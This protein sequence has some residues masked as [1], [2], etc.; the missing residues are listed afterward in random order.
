RMARDAGWETAE[1]PH[2]SVALF[3][4]IFAYFTN[5]PTLQRLA[6]WS[7]DPLSARALDVQRRFLARA[8]LRLLAPV[9][10]TGRKKVHHG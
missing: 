4:M 5:A 9:R 10:P 7:D 6:G 1:I 2:L 8:M 3:G